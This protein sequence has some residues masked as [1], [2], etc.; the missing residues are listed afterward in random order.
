M[1]TKPFKILVCDKNIG[2]ALIDNKLYLKLASE[3]IK[4]DPSYSELKEDPLQRTTE[5]INFILDKFFIDADI[6]IDMRDS[7]KNKPDEIKT[8]NFKML[9]KLHKKEFGW[10]PIID[11][12]G[13]PTSRICFLIDKIFQPFVIQ[14]D[15][16]LKDSQNLVQKCANLDFE[17]PPILYFS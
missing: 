4:N 7:L 5:K 12:I 8:V 3:F 15:S 16:Y 13:H 14:T 6:S 2:N 1:K 17:K 9:A 10:R 11:S